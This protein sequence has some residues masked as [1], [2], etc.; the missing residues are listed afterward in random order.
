MSE[1]SS[2]T[3][4][5]LDFKTFVPLGWY[6]GG[7]LLGGAAGFITWVKKKGARALR[8]FG[9]TVGRNEAD[10]YL[11]PM[12]RHMGE[13][14]DRHFFYDDQSTDRTPYIVAEYSHA[15]LERRPNGV[16]SFVENEGAFRGAAW[17][18]FEW[19]MQPEPG[20]YVLVIDCDEVLVSTR[21]VDF[22]ILKYGVAAC[23]RQRLKYV[24]DQAINRPINLNIPEVFG[25]DAEGYPL[26]R[27]DRLWN[28]IHAPRLFPYRPSGHYFIGAKGFGVP[29]VPNYVMAGGWY[30]TDDLA[31][32]HYGYAREEDQK[33]KFERYSGQ[34]G[35]SNAHV[36]S[37]AAA[38]KTLATWGLAHVKEMQWRP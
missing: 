26:I 25:F 3:L 1:V 17:E 13:V 2:I 28:T 16:P 10:R 4:P 24:I 20:D 9:L 7:G 23:T 18:A 29:A 14:L 27:T 12:L 19:H 35:H 8:I 31:L 34:L 21:L 36:E 5:P 30:S 22:N 33:L 11:I 32:M 38:D 6:W 37:I 15:I